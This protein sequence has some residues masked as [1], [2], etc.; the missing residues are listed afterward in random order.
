MIVGKDHFENAYSQISFNAHDKVHS[1]ELLEKACYFEYPCDIIIL[2]NG[3][4]REIS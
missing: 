3:I 4:G 1:S 2:Q